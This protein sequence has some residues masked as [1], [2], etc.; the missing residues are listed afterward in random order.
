MA[1]NKMTANQIEAELQTVGETGNAKVKSG[2]LYV[3][4]EEN[5]D[6]QFAGTVADED[7]AKEI[8]A[9]YFE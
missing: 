6:W 7:E 2:G 3:Q 8:V 1:Q 5:C 9:A 4:R